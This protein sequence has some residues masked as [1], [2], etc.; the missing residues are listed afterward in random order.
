LRTRPEI[1]STTASSEAV[2]CAKI[3]TRGRVHPKSVRVSVTGTE[4]AAT[5]AVILARVLLPGMVS[6]GRRG[7]TGQQGRAIAKSKLR[8]VMLMLVNL[9]GA[10][11]RS[12]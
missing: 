8:R 9:G 7:A 12:S 2:T 11:R 4:I 6:N 5:V 10:L 3:E 1:L